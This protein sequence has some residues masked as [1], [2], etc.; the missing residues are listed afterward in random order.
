VLAGVVEH[1]ELT[2]HWRAGVGTVDRAEVGAGIRAAVAAY[3]EEQT[4]AWFVGG[5]IRDPSRPRRQATIP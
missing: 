5:S 2:R 4:H 3:E 1:H